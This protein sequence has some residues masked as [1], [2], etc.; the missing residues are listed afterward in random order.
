MRPGDHTG[1]N[2][3]D[4]FLVTFFTGPG[5]TTKREERLDRAALARL[6]QTTSRSEKADLPWLKLARFGDR[7]SAKGSLRSNANVLAICGVEGDYD[8]GTMG[9]DDAAARLTAA[10]ITALVYSSP[11]HS[12]D[13]PRWRALC[14]LSREYRPD[15]R[16]ALMARLN[17]LFGGVFAPES[18]TLSQAYY[19]GAV[20]QNPSH[21]AL[22]TDGDFIDLRD[23]LDQGA[24]GRPEKPSNGPQ[25][26]AATA[27]RPADISDARIH[28]LTDALLAKVRNAVDGTKHPTLRD[29]ALA[30]GGYLHLIGWSDSEAIERL[31]EA[32]PASVKDWDAARQTAAWGIA[33]GQKAPL[34]LADRPDRRERVAAPRPPGKQHDQERASTAA[35]STPPAARP[36][37]TMSDVRS[38]MTRETDAWANGEGPAVV[39]NNATTS[40][41]KG[42]NTLETL[43]RRAAE[44]RAIRKRFTQDWRRDHPG[45]SAHEAADAADEAGLRPLRIG[46]LGDNHTVVAQHVQTAARL[47]M[48]TAHDAGIDRPYDPADPT[49]PPRCTQKDRVQQTRLAGEPVR[50]HACGLDM[51]GPHC[52]DRAGCRDWQSIGECAHAEFVGMVADRATAHHMPRYLRHFDVVLIDEPPDRVFRPERDVMLDLLADHLVERHPVRSSDGQPDAAATAEARAMLDTLRF[53]INDM[54]NGYW[55]KDAMAA[56]GCDAAFFERLIELTD[57]RDAKTG[58]TAATPDH[59]RAAMARTS[60]RNQV[61]KLCAFFR[62]AQAIQAGEEGSGRLEIAGDAPRIA[63][64]RPRAQIHPSLLQARIMVTGAGLDIERVRSWLPDV[65]PMGVDALIPH[66]P[67]QTLVH[68]HKGMGKGAMANPA[69]RDWVK[70]LIALEGDDSRPDATGVSVFKQHE[71]EFAGL[72]GVCASHPGAM[73]GRKEWEACTTFFGVGARFLSPVD[74]AAAGAAETGEEVPVKRPVRKERM[75]AMRDGRDVPVPVFEYEHP[76]AQAALSGV[77]DFDVR[78]GQ[79]ARPRAPNRTAA[80][81]VR[82]FDLGMHV[83]H[84]ALVDVL[85]TSA[86]QY[87]PDRFVRMIAAGLAVEHSVGRNRLHPAIYGQPWTGQNDQRLEA[88]GFIATALRVLCPPWRIGPREAWVIGRYWRPGHARRDAGEAFV[89]TQRQLDAN[90]AALREREGATRIKVDR[91]VQPQ[92]RP[93]ELAINAQREVHPPVIVSSDAPAPPPPA[94]G[95][96]PVW[97]TFHPPDG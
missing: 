61:R 20:K 35:P 50:L 24:I 52:I 19:Y 85:I 11:S 56:V 96:E 92:P 76:A 12:V 95:A 28:G 73:V 58:M 47:G 16:D 78:Q 83:P 40:A 66:A 97:R 36:N 80:D 4:R 53:V 57:R 42:K 63:I 13:L 64:M 89:S 23:D 54:Q 2:A 55:P 25:Y 37:C 93:E 77:R 51:D 86:E 79:L 34:E 94:F 15:Q 26:T 3:P 1:L 90:M 22:I 62:L 33:Q 87:A 27:T 18:W 38:V 43:A 70:A 67:H 31:V 68:I 59:E 21:R 46:Y 7:R 48:I 41:G 17:G 45:S 74:A 84:G 29:T 10:G 6:I 49:S 44:H 72:P 69:R 9:I 88:D 82:V 81:P 39:L 91:T 75:I 65:Q 30:L 71:H 14:P 8:G 32:L 60:F 5:A